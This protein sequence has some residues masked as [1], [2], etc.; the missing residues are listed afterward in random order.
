MRINKPEIINLCKGL[1]GDIID[2]QLSPHNNESGTSMYMKTR[3][4][5]SARKRVY[6]GC[7]LNYIDVVPLSCKHNLEKVFDF[8]SNL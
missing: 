8:F 7:I 1:H 3:R 6:L 5:K 4:I 2:C